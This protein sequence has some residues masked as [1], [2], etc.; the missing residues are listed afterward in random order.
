MRRCGAAAID[1][2]QSI[3][4]HRCG[5]VVPMSFCRLFAAA[6]RLIAGMVRRQ[7]WHPET[8]G[9][10]PHFGR[11][12]E[13]PMHTDSTVRERPFVMAMGWG[14]RLIAAFGFPAIDEPGNIS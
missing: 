1:A 8:G 7:L 3:G 13:P 10:G 2:T 11:E 5:S 9:S 12:L 4:V 6:D 14:A